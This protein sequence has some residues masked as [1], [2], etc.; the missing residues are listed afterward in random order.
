MP[1]YRVAELEGFALDRVASDVAGRPDLYLATDALIERELID[2]GPIR[3]LETTWQASK[4]YER[5]GLLHVAVSK[6][7]T[8]REAVLRCFL[9]SRAE[10]GDVVTTEG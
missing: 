4:P 7:H 6:G 9:Q 2:V 3:G 5:G 8:L 1:R 10:H